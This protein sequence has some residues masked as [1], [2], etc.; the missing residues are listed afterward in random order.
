MNIL[1]SAKRVVR[2][3]G[4]A[5]GSLTTRVVRSGIW[6]GVSNAALNVLQTVRTIVLA[7]LLTPEMFGLMGISSVVMR[8]LNLFTETGIAPG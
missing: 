2:F 8:A 6:V 5:D 1:Y 4:G 7:W 3:L